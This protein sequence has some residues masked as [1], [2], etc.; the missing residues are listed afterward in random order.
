MMG[1]LVLLRHGRSVWNERNIFTGWVDIPLSEKGV[2]EAISAGKRIQHI[3]FDLIVTSTL[4]RAQMTAFLAA[5]QTASGKLPC[6]IHERDPKHMQ[7]SKVYDAATEKSLI[8]VYAYPELNE[9][10]YGSLQGCDKA[11]ILEKHGQEQFML[12]RRSYHVSPPEGESLE[13]TAKRALPFFEKR[14][15]P[16]L[17]KGQHVLIAAHGNS[18]RAIMMFLDHLSEEEIVKL[19]I[20]TGEPI[21][22]N[23][24]NINK[25]TKQP[26]DLCNQE[27]KK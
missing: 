22:Y 17:A 4:I 10:M 23:F 27:F 7:M 25:W 16:S 1:K 9:R 20:P 6:M 26:V 13:M 2:E 3:P 14:I 11:K 5:I 8:P 18:L 12:W 24:E 15:L 19:E 21:C